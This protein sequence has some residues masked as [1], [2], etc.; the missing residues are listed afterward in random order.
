MVFVYFLALTHPL[1]ALANKTTKVQSLCESSNRLSCK[2]WDDRI[3]QMRAEREALRD[4]IAGSLNPVFFWSEGR[5][6]VLLA[7]QRRLR[8]N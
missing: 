1:S 5:L 3:R 8:E 6:H 4:R 7:E 2:G